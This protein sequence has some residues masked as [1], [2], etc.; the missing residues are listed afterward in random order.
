MTSELTRP[1]SIGDQGLE[2]AGSGGQQ[3]YNVT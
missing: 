3:T 1:R 2:K